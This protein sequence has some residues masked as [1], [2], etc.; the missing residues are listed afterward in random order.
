MY[1]PRAPLPTA[2]PYPAPCCA[3]GNGAATLHLKPPTVARCAL[4]NTSSKLC[5][6]WGPLPASCVFATPHL[7]SHVSPSGACASLFASS[8]HFQSS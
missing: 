5:R 2:P 8:G 4:P 7:A 1:W 3:H 6:P